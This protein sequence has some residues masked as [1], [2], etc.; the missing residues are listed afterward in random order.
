M[1][2]NV[3]KTAVNGTD[4]EAF[5]TTTRPIGRWSAQ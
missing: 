5:K 3:S 4:S 2:K 1:D